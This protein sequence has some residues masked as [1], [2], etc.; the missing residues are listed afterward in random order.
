MRSLFAL[1]LLQLAAFAVAVGSPQG[2]ASAVKAET[3]TYGAGKD[4]A[5]TSRAT[6]SPSRTGALSAA[7][8][9]SRSAT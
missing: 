9:R 7:R 8:S 4:T 5:G 3:V 1:A 2:K 6:D